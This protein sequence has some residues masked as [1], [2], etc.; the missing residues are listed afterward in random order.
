MIIKKENAKLEVDQP[1]ARIFDYNLS[2]F[3][4]GISYQELDGRVPE[5]GAGRNAVCEELYYILDGSAEIW[6]DEVKYQAEPGDVVMIK[7]GS[8][9]YLIA[10]NLRILTIT[11]PDWY[12]DQHE[13]V[14]E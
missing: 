3:Q 4:A 2:P 11:V 5:S 6:I 9:S 12:E 13:N 1:G 8:P 10:D 7:P 14:R